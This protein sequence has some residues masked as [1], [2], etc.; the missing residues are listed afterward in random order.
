M[1]VNAARERADNATLS[2]PGA[3]AIAYGLIAVARAIEDAGKTIAK[4]LAQRPGPGTERAY[5]SRDR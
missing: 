4:A 2:N 1:D 3:T 5:S